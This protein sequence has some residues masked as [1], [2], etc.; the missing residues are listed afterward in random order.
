MSLEACFGRVN[1]FVEITNYASAEQT[2]W[3]NGM[4]LRKANLNPMATQRVC[5]TKFVMLWVCNWT[6]HGILSILY[7]M[8]PDIL[9]L[10]TAWAMSC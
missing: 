6:E 5:L 9:E 2:V 7:Y 8:G 3:G 4:P 1:A 10:Q